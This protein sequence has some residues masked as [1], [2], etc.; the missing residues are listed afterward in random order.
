MIKLFLVLNNETKKRT[1]DKCF[2]SF[3]KGQVIF[4]E[5]KETFLRKKFLLKINLMKLI[6]V[7]IYMLAQP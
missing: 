6:T 1:L 7:D 4:L 5:K 2:S 3:S